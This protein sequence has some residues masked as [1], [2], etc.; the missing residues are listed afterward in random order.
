MP[1]KSYL[2]FLGAEVDRDPRVSR[3]NWSTTECS[4]SKC[5]YKQC[6][7]HGR[8]C[9]RMCRTLPHADRRFRQRRAQYSTLRVSVCMPFLS[10]LGSLYPSPFTTS[11]L[12]LCGG[13]LLCCAR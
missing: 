5:E 6:G 3:A 13:I 8:S 7:R 4:E 2:G 1:I 11:L 10:T 12:L 9:V